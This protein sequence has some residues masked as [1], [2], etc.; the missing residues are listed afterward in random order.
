MGDKNL[1]LRLRRLLSAFGDV[2]GIL[3][4]VYVLP[5]VV[6]ALG[7]PVAL[8]VLLARLLVRLTAAL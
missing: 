2:G 6:L 7:I 4:V 5:L 3:A 8:V 1:R